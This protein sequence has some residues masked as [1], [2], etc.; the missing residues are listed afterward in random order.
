[1][2]G[3]GKTGP[4][5]GE[6]QRDRSFRVSDWLFL[7]T[8]SCKAEVTKERGRRET[9]LVAE[10][11]FRARGGNKTVSD[12]GP[13][14][15]KNVSRERERTGP[16]LQ[17]CP[18]WHH[19]GHCQ[20][21]A[22]RENLRANGD[23]KKGRKGTDEII[24]LSQYRTP[25]RRTCSVRSRQLA[26][27]E[28]DRDADDEGRTFVVN[29]LKDWGTNAGGGT[30]LR[31]F[32]LVQEE[33]RT[34]WLASVAEKAPNKPRFGMLPRRNSVWGLHGISFSALLSFSA[35]SP[36]L[37]PDD[38]IHPTFQPS[39]VPPRPCSNGPASSCPPVQTS[40]QTTTMTSLL[41]LSELSVCLSSPPLSLP[42]PP[43]SLLAFLADLTSR[44]M[45]G[46]ENRTGTQS[47]SITST[48]ATTVPSR[49]ALT[50][51]ARGT[52]STRFWVGARLR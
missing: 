19:P 23:G 11:L 26:E 3:G 14:A 2:C 40:S 13:G 49:T 44:L 12:G 34:G 9:D 16:C 33:L 52:R 8:P 46:W 20:S 47:T 17:A 22:L 30:I 21:Y 37:P 51:P 27:L 15:K 25:V 39:C 4:K 36:S 50:F 29:L 41:S 5:V 18:L 32:G 10:P 48:S 31:E 6:D 43:P 24:C 45:N 1:M 42:A 35:L 7:H 28:S 38:R